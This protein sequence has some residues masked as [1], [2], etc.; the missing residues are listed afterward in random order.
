[1]PNMPI[2]NWA[3]WGTLVM[4]WVKDA[5]TRPR[6]I[7]SLN[8]Q[9]QRANVGGAFSQQDY[10]SLAFC[11]APDDTTLQLFLPTQNQVNSAIQKLN[12]NPWTLPDF[13]SRDAFNGQPVSVKDADK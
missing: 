6:D 10:T 13:Y 1:M 5:N 9:M 8:Q 11:Q 12:N 3:A 7:A 4:G 2:T